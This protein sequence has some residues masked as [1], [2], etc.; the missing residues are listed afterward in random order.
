[1]RQQKTFKDSLGSRIKFSTSRNSGKR[2]S[3]FIAITQTEDFRDAF[4]NLTF[5]Q[6][7]QLYYELEEWVRIRTYSK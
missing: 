5:T 4:V 3:L 6:A 2:D 1:M 7:R